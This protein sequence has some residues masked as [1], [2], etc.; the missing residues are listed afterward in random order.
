MY[1]CPFWSSFLPCCVLF[2]LFWFGKTCTGVPFGW[3]AGP[4]FFEG[5][6]VSVGSRA[7]DQI[8][9]G[10]FPRSAVL[11]STP[12]YTLILEVPYMIH[13]YIHTCSQGNVPFFCATLQRSN[14]INQYMFSAN[15][16]KAAAHQTWKCTSRLQKG[17]LVF[18]G[19]RGLPCLLVALFVV[20]LR[21]VL[22]FHSLSFRA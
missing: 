3:L 1:G 8:E 17:F 2:L 13:V 15:Q 6:G 18:E 20:D 5:G 9:T 14:L 21:C 19:L 4:L 16:H 11:R 7:W 12:G 22:D 10:H